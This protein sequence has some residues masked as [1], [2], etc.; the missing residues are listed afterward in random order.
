VKCV[1]CKESDTSVVDSRSS[2]DSSSTRR[3][4]ECPACGKRFTTY[5]RPQVNVSII[6][7]DGRREDFR[8]EKI[9]NGLKKACEK[10]GISVEA[11]EEFVQ[12]LERDLT[13]KGEREIPSAEIGGKVMENLRDLDKVA[14]LRFASVYKSFEDLSEFLDEMKNI[15]G[16]EMK[17]RNPETTDPC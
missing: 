9:V 4:R 12:R 3:R 13:E 10:R 16:E 15:S 11:I 2:E 5:E 17:L 8:R 7:K 14:Y 1:F 6:K